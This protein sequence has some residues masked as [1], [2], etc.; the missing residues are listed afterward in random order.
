M[1]RDANVALKEVTNPKK[2]R[3]HGGKQRRLP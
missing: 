1:E 3:G 2:R